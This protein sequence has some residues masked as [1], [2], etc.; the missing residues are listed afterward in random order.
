MDIQKITWT[1]ATLDY[2]YMFTGTWGIPS[3]VFHI[4][5]GETYPEYEFILFYMT[6]ASSACMSDDTQS[7]N[8]CTLTQYDTG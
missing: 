1:R 3:R 4:S 5:R 6:M 8:P 2:M 7:K